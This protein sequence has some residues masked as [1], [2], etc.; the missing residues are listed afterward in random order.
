MRAEQGARQVRGAGGAGVSAGQGL[1][2]G[3]RT[4]RSR[5]GGGCPFPAPAQRRPR[6]RAASERSELEGG[7]RGRV[8]LPAG[9]VR[10]RWR[11]GEVPVFQGSMG[12][13]RGEQGGMAGGVPVSESGGEGR[14]NGG[15]EWRSAR[16]GRCG[17]PVAERSGRGWS[18]DPVASGAGRE[19]GME[20]VPVPDGAGSTALGHGDRGG[21]GDETSCGVMAPKPRCGPR[22]S[23]T[24]SGRPC[25]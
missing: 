3:G 11:R 23:A 17:V 9:R 21:V 13:S 8:A 19:G 6:L 25:R 7:A 14:R 1:R 18:A 2:G 16:R 5:S 20:M 24:G 12:G 10:G 4:R 15:G 22:P